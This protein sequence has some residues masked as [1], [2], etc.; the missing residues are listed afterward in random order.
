MGWANIK[1]TS[2]LLGPIHFSADKQHN[3]LHKF[4]FFI[5]I[6]NEGGENR[7]LR[8]YDQF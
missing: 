4:H 5:L 1:K 6:R 2:R 3:W 8:V 7:A